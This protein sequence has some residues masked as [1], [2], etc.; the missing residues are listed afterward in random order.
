MSTDPAALAPH[1]E[2][3]WLSDFVVELRLRDVPGDAVGA[4][5]VE[6]ETHCVDSGSDARDAFG[7][8]AEY[9]AG[10]ADALGTPPGGPLEARSAVGTVGQLAG[11]LALLHAGVP[12]VRGET[13]EVS[14]G[15]L[16]CVT[17]LVGLAA[18]AARFPTATLRRVLAL[19]P[20]RAALGGML[21]LGEQVAIML[22]APAHAVTA[23]AP[24]VA[25]A[26]AFVLLAATVAV[27]TDPA[28]PD[29][30]RAP[31]RPVDHA[32]ERRTWRRWSW[33]SALVV[34]VATVVLL[35]VLA[36]LPS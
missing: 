18:L 30:V 35:G 7:D 31:G 34:P 29:V 10:L 32:A 14:V 9:A 19:G 12:A 1:V 21:L 4:A 28:D 15:A 17:L 13:L 23:A 3:R 26:G 24:P 33:Q 20:W 22:L 36:A 27:G 5:V 2:P 16:V 25:I 8:P 11:M 6:V